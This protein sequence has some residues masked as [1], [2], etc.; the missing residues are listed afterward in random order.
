MEN[1]IYN[2]NRTMENSI[3][4]I[5]FGWF[6]GSHILEKPHAWMAMSQKHGTQTV[7]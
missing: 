4:S 3:Y 1:P 6:E 7:H 2:L 5:F